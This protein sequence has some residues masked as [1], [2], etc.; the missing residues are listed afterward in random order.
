MNQ[1]SHALRYHCVHCGQPVTD[2]LRPL[3]AGPVFEGFT[4]EPV[5][6]RGTS[7]TVDAPEPRWWPSLTAGQVIVHPEDLI[8]VRRPM[9]SRPVNN[10]GARRVLVVY[11]RTP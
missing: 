7:W 6:P 4:T 10:S 1:V 3:A 11:R 2:A 8:N 5:M 9:T